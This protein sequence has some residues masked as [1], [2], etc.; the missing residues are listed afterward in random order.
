MILKLNEKML[1]ANQIAE[2]LN[3]NI[4]KTIRS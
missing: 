3:F 4:S 1:F 2:F